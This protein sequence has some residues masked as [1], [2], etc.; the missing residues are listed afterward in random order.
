MMHAKELA[1]NKHLL[2]ISYFW[3]QRF[4]NVCVLGKQWTDV[5]NGGS[6]VLGTN[7]WPLKRWQI[8]SLGIEILDA[9]PQRAPWRV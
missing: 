1:Q 5:E 8:L 3:T 4:L 9:I 2:N 6:R 7:L